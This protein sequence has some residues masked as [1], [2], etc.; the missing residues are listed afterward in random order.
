MKQITRVILSLALGGQ[1]CA[2]GSQEQK[3]PE[4]A[5]AIGMLTGFIHAADAYRSL[6]RP[7]VPA[8]EHERYIGSWFTRNQALSSKIFEAGSKMQWG[9]QPGDYASQW[10]QSWEQDAKRIRL[11]IAESIASEPHLMCIDG[12]RPFREKNYE[13]SYFPFHLRA[14][15]VAAE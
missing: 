8:A 1:V 15:G 3:L 11:Q 14:I 6:C 5:F 2:V 4:P 12:M 7:H 13:L 9:I 10:Q